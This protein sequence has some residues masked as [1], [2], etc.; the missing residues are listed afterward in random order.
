[1]DESLLKDIETESRQAQKRLGY[2]PN[3]LHPRTFNEHILHKKFFNRSLWLV[4][5]TDKVAVYDYVKLAGYEDILI[6]NYYVTK[7]PE[8]IPFDTLPEE[9]IIKPNQLSGS[10][11]YIQKGNINRGKI[12]ETCKKWLSETHYGKKKFIWCTSLVTPK[13]I[14]QKLIAP[15]PIDYKFHMINGRCAFIGIHNSDAIGSHPR[16]TI[17]Y[18]LD[19]NILPFIF[20]QELAKP[21]PKPKNLKKMLD[22]AQRLSMPFKYVRVDF[23]NIDGKIYFGE[24]THFPNS[25][26]GRFIPEKWDYKFGELFDKK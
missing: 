15:H 26:A 7:K 19:W 1:M 13:I 5:T 17:S 4:I 9:Y 18:D 20:E 16:Y 3:I 6:P 12:I 21:V 23:Y 2:Y 22:I 11:M 24:L 25:G 8:L 10:I 14:V